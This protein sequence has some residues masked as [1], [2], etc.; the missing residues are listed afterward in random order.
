MGVGKEGWSGGEQSK[1][2]RGI[3]LT[4]DVNQMQI[5]CHMKLLHIVK[6]TRDGTEERESLVGEAPHPTPSQASRL[7]KVLQRDP[8]ATEKENTEKN[9]GKPLRSL[10]SLLLLLFGGGQE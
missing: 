10:R 9:L 6:L 1:A 7:V 3:P 5:K 4:F 2:R 8:F